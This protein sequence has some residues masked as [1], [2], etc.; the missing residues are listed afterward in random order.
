[1]R[2]LR[3]R[4]RSSIYHSCCGEWL[5]GGTAH[6]EIHLVTL[7]GRAAQAPS[8]IG[9]GGFVAVAVDLIGHV[10]RG[11]VPAALAPYDQPDLG[12]EA[13]RRACEIRLRAERKAG[14]LLKATEKAKGGR[15]SQTPPRGGG[16]STDPYRAGRLREAIAQLAE[17]GRRA[18][19]E[20]RGSA[21]RPDVQAVDQRRGMYEGA[22]RWPHTRAAAGPCRS[23]SEGEGAIRRPAGAR[24]LRSNSRQYGRQS[25]NSHGPLFESDNGRSALQPGTALRAPYE[26]FAATPA[27]CW[28]GQEAAIRICS[29]SH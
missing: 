19:G 13:E 7:V 1:M 16:F 26:P 22:G 9:N 8:P 12:R 3:L 27:D 17:A 2:C 10:G 14:E 18:A 5:S 25:P 15:P 29:S 4:G 28:V 24:L 23:T 11:P 21:R 6:D 20:I